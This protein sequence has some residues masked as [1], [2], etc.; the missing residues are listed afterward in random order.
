MTQLQTSQDSYRQMVTILQGDGMQQQLKMACA[1]TITPERMARIV[2]TELKMQPKLLNCTPQ[3]IL[4]AMMECA[5]VGLEPGGTLG[6]AYLIP[7]GKECQFQ[8]GYRGLIQLLWRS[9][10]VSSV[11]SEVVYDC[12][13]FEY[14]NGIPQ[15]LKHVPSDDRPDDA[16]PTHAY[17]VIGTV[18]GG[19]VMRVMTFFQIEQHRKAYSKDTRKD[20]A[21]VT[22]WD[23]Q[24]CKTVI[25]RTAKRAPI[26]T[27]AQHAI[28]LDD[29]SEV[30]VT[31][32]LGNAID[33]EVTV[34]VDPGNPALDD[35]PPDDWEPSE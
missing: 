4:G 22:A 18:S 31:Q 26:S 35:A 33:V 23:E 7:Y 32:G 2:L 20:A 10:M 9:E 30:G 1:R 25:K 17:C 28:T 19:Y 14:A 15:V 3:S 16:M 5:Q 21:W 6:L 24:A 34:P 11:Q 8:I 12:D 13:Y 29:M 27:E